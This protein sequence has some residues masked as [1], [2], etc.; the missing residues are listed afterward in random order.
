MCTGSAVKSTFGNIA[1]HNDSLQLVEKNRCG[2]FLS[3]D[4]FGVKQVNLASV[5]WLEVWRATCPAILRRA[6]WG[7]RTFAP[8]RGSD[9]KLA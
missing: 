6:V 8:D 3:W 9:L 5:Q 1:C 4:L 2:F 7:S